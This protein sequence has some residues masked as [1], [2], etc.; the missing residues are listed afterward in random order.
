[1]QRTAAGLSPGTGVEF[2]APDRTCSVA[3]CP[4]VRLLPVGETGFG[5]RQWACLVSFASRWVGLFPFECAS[6]TSMRPTQQE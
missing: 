3:A 5:A 4:V 6:S 1:M 2:E